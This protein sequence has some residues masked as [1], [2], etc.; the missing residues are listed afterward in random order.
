MVKV[1]VFQR[2]DVS[3]DMS[4]KGEVVKASLQDMELP[5]LGHP[6]VTPPLLLGVIVILSFFAGVGGEKDLSASP[7]RL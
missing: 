3:S 6:F 1:C 2:I 5:Q 7:H 4:T